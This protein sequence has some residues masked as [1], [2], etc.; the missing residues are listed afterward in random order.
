VTFTV[1]KTKNAS[2]SFAG[3]TTAVV[4]TNANGIAIAPTLTANS[5]TTANGGGT[6]KVNATVAALPSSVA[7]FALTNIAP[8]TITAANLN[9]SAQQAETTGTVTLATFTDPDLAL[10]NLSNYSA[11]INWEDGTTGVGTVSIANGELVVTG[12]HTYAT[13][14]KF[15]AHITLTR[16]ST[17]T[18]AVAVANFTIDPTA[19]SSGLVFSHKTNLYNGTITLTNYGTTP[20][21]GELELVFAGVPTTVKLANATGTNASGQ[22]YLLVPLATP[23][24]PGQ[25]I[26]VSVEFANTSNLLISYALGLYVIT[27]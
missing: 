21:S 26:S 7:T 2:A 19:V 6:Y 3:A 16:A 10:F 1:V 9:L 11:S 8:A 5:Y 22:F 14:G 27:P 12:S 17:S 15:G 24:A 18:T 13:A 25:S 23:L 4:T 20:L